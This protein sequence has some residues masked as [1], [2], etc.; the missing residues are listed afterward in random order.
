MKLEIK[1]DYVNLH[2]VIGAETSLVVKSVLIFF[3]VCTLGIVIL[4]LIDWLLGLFVIGSILMGLFAWLTLWF[5]YGKERIIINTKSISYQYQYGFYTTKIETQPIKKALNIS[6]A[7]ARDKNGLEYFNLIFETYNKHNVPE[8]I[9]RSALA[10][11]R[12]EFATLKRSVRALYFEKVDAEYL[13]QPY[14]L[15]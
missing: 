14:I 2:V 15:N 8:E 7:P 13:K 5:G 11:T 3:N 4:S 6:L 12:P 9:Y 1:K 10:I